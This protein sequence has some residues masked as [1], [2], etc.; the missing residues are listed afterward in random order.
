MSGKDP[1]GRKTATLIENFIRGPPLAL[2]LDAF[3]QEIFRALHE[4]YICEDLFEEDK[5]QDSDES[6][7]VPMEIVEGE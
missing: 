3:L 6:S 7:E 4:K 5:T 1:S 2:E